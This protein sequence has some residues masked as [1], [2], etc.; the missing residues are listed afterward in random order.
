MAEER[1]IDEDKDKKYRVKVNADGEE[2]LIIEGGEQKTESVE[3]V[4]FEVPEQEEID[5][6]AA[7]MTPEQYAAK[8]EEE[9]LERE[10]ILAQAC[11][12]IKKA[13]ADCKEEKY[14]TALEYLEQA[15]ELDE[16]N[17]DIYALRMS[18]Y[19]RN[20]TDYE[21][22]TDAA[23]C[24]DG[25][26][27]Y[28]SAEVKGKI[29]DKCMTYVDE[30]IAQLRKTVTALNK[31]N[32]EKKAERAV[33]FKSSAKKAAVPFAFALLF[34]IAACVATA[35]FASIIYTVSTGLYLIL[36]IAFGAC[37][38][39]MLVILAL[40]ARKLLIACRRIS[41]NKR[42][43]STALGRELLEKQNT[44]KAFIDIRDCLKVE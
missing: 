4:S 10:R 11:E 21:L 43:T 1:L 24:A 6:E 5:E 17:G 40:C 3:E 9:R 37:A 25:I 44:L 19:T 23:E 38:L 18:A 14:A 2:E 32:E 30:Q 31:E 39:I 8:I 12:L 29:A 22:V 7:V 15:Q 42:N 27:K 36:T 26:S 33:V 16:T 41:A 13:E 34:L 35:Y 20:F 28:A